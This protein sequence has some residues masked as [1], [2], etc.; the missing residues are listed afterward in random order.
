VASIGRTW[1]TGRGSRLAHH[2]L[3]STPGEKVFELAFD[4]GMVRWRVV[5]SWGRPAMA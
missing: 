3:V 1:S 2:Y 5:R 4:P